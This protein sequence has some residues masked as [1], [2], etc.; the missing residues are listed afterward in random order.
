MFC[1]AFAKKI[2][3]IE[4]QGEILL[5]FFDIEKLPDYPHNG[6]NDQLE[7]FNTQYTRVNNISYSKFSKVKKKFFPPKEL[8][9]FQ[10]ILYLYHRCFFEFFVHKYN[11]KSRDELPNVLKSYS[12]YL[13]TRGLYIFP[14]SVA[15]A[16]IKNKYTNYFLYSQF[17][18]AEYYKGEQSLLYNEFV[19][20]I[21][22]RNDEMYNEILNSESVCITIRRGDFLSTENIN[23]FFQC[24]TKYFDESI[25]IIKEKINNP[26]FFFFSDDIIFAEEY[27]NSILDSK[28]KYYIENEG[29]S[30]Y[31]KIRLMTTCKHFV[32]SNST[33]SW[34]CQYLGRHSEK[35]VVGPKHWHFHSLDKRYDLLV[36][37]TWLKINNEFME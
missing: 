21:I 9:F 29:N 20:D 14:R 5:D 28:D 19:P 11:N 6:W 27:A 26:T 18:N 23:S 7:Y 15:T 2:L 4:G 10:K 3:L 30:I 8:N 16:P 13:A 22:P 24:G 1:Y 35:L 25:R 37:D 34:W 12:T 36:Q 17:E 32:I 31:E 33:F